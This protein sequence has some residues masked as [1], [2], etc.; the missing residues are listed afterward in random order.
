MPDLS[1][2]QIKQCGRQCLARMKREAQAAQ[3]LCERLNATAR[4]VARI[5]REG[6]ELQ[7]AKRRPL[8]ASETA[9][10]LAALA[11]AIVR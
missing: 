9:R 4:A 11:S 3:Q 6:L 10:R 1:A 2:A 8:T 7:R 5:A